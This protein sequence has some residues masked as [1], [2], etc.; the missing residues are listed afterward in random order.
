MPREKRRQ[1]KENHRTR[2]LSL[3]CVVVAILLGTALVSGRVLELYQETQTKEKDGHIESESITHADFE[4]HVIDVGQ[5]DSVL[6]IADGEAMLVDT[7][8]YSSNDTLLAYLEDEGI[9]E[10]RYLVAT[11]MHADHIGGVPTVVEHFV[12]DT[13]LEPIYADSLTPTTATFTR[14]L[15]AIEEVEDYCTVQGGDCF[16]LGTAEIT[17]LAPLQEDASDLNNTSVVL[18]IEYDDIV[19]LL[20]GDMGESEESELLACGYDL[21]A[22]YLK[23]GHHGSKT[24]STE[25]F[26]AAVQP[27]VA[28]IS[29]GVDNSYGHPTQETL[30]RLS[31]WTD[32]I[33]ITATVGDVVFT[34]DSE[35]GE[36]ICVGAKS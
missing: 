5:G 18:R 20:T 1:I 31:V 6:V 19:W 24:S 9:K 25:E 33:Y 22:N 23:V 14:Y 15:D 2:N 21:K 30:D 26:L 13:I 4:V 36:S 11:H 10:I 35:D 16:T 27:S 28:V 3:Y 34:Y 12:V 7:G 32:E 29:C 8:D 17:V